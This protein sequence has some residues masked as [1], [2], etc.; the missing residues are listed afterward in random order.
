MQVAYCL[1]INLYC[2]HYGLA[3]SKRDFVNLSVG[4]AAAVKTKRKARVRKQ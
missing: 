1:P 4:I 2:Q 3:G